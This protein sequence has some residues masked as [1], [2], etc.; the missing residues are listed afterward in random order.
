MYTSDSTMDSNGVEDTAKAPVG[1]EGGS[2]QIDETAGSE[3]H[4]VQGADARPVA[5]ADTGQ[6]SGAGGTRK[7]TRADY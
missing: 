4:K 2:P 7:Y 1:C 6:P 3:S 5:G